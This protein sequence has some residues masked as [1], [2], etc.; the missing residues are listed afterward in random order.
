MRV[1]CDA[2][3][4]DD[5]RRALE[6]LVGEID[7]LDSL[8][9]FQL[10][11]GQGMAVD[12]VTAE[13]C[14]TW[15]AVTRLQTWVANLLQIGDLGILE[16]GCESDHARHIFAIFGEVVLSQAEGKWRQTHVER[17]QKCDRACCH[18]ATNVGGKL[19]SD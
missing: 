15:P 3:A 11:D 19:T 17:F 2:G 6:P 9:A 4:D 18:T 8:D 14:V 5:G 16:C 7:R 10:V 1:P 13:K 12:T